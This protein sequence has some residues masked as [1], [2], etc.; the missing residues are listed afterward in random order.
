MKHRSR[1]PTD[2]QQHANITKKAITYTLCP[3]PGVIQLMCRA[4]TNLI[5]H[6]TI[7]VRRVESSRPCYQAL[8]N[9]IHSQVIVNSEKL[10]WYRYS[11]CRFVKMR[12]GGATLATNC[13]KPKRLCMSL[14]VA[15][16]L[17]IHCSTCSLTSLIFC[18]GIFIVMATAS[19]KM[20]SHTICCAGLHTLCRASCIPSSSI[21]AYK[22]L[23]ASSAAPSIASAPP[24]SSRFGLDK[25]PL[26]P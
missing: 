8:Y 9:I 15:C 14:C 21:I 1:C 3:V 17:P 19:N 25:Y 4:C 6:K 10:I 18:C 23:R 12:A 13:S 5:V 20:P 7:A 11:L 2:P 24:K 26:C 22:V 16:I